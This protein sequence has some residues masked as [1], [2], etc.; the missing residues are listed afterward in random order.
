MGD[1][2]GNISAVDS[3]VS[4][5]LASPIISSTTAETTSLLHAGATSLLTAGASSMFSN[6]S[7]GASAIS[8]AS[9]P[10]EEESAVISRLVSQPPP[11]TPSKDIEDCFG[12]DEDD[13]AAP[14]V[15]LMTGDDEDDEGAEDAAG[16]L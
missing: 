14:N 6:N 12:F 16:V 9:T 1:E 4:P 7:E 8:L 13:D 15:A 11:K 2:S 5:S 10:E 3:Q